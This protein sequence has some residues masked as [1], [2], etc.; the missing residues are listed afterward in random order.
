MKQKNKRN[1][2]IFKSNLLLNL[3]RQSFVI[4]TSK[5]CS[6]MCNVYCLYQVFNCMIKKFNL[7]EFEKE[8]LMN[9][10]LQVALYFNVHFTTLQVVINK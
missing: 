9:V 2:F 5:T 8:N 4:R 3:S 1:N 6:I 7:Y 10:S